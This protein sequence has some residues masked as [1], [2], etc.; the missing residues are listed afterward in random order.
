M[1]RL[2]FEANSQTDESIVHELTATT[3]STTT[4]NKSGKAIS[5]VQFEVTYK[6]ISR[7][8]QGAVYAIEFNDQD[9][10][11]GGG[12]MVSINDPDLLLMIFPGVGNH[13]LT[14][15]KSQ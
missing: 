8:D 6:W 7:N 1:A 9:G 15:V 3:I 12:V 4:I 11:S 13:Q 14:S 2:C 5:Q 10:K